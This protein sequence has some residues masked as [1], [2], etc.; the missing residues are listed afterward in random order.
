MQTGFN[1]KPYK[2]LSGNSNV[3][4]YMFLPDSIIVKFRSG[5]YTFYKYSA[6]SCG[7]NTVEHLKRLALQ[8]FSLNAELARRGHPSYEAKGRTLEAIL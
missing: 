1:M 3:V 6:A 8:G 2:N 5:S 7:A 4:A